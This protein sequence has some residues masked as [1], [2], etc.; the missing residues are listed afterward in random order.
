MIR[1][2]ITGA[3]GRM[4]QAVIAALD[5]AGDNKLELGGAHARPG[6]ALVGETIKGVRVTSDLAEM[7]ADVDLVID[8]T[9]PEFTTELADA[10]SRAATPLVSGTTGLGRTE[11]QALETLALSVPVF[12]APNMSLGVNLLLQAVETIAARLG[13]D[14]DVEIVEAHHRHKQDAPSGTALALGERVAAA[15]DQDFA[16]VV[17]HGREGSTGARKRG[18]IGMHS[19]RGGEIVGEHDV[20]FI[21]G[22]EELRLGHSAFSRRAFADGALR[23]AAWLNEQAPGLYRFS[24]LLEGNKP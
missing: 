4:G 9:L 3:G 2:G 13:Q 5:T 1:I 21:A 22:G 19:L 17:E 18:Q 7:L 12:H 23:A 10:C 6:S 24:D 16:S 14:Y 20:R 15:R 11:W 8:F